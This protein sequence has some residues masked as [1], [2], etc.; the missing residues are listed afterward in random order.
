MRSSIAR[1]FRALY[2]CLRPFESLFLYRLPL[3]LLRTKKGPDES[4]QGAKIIALLVPASAPM[5]AH[6]GSV[7]MGAKC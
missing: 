6:A 3:Y 1:T 2:A 5:L 7:P 4:G